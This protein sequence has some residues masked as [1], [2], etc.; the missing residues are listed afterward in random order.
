MSAEFRM[1]SNATATYDHINFLKSLTIRLLA[2]QQSLFPT[3]Y[4][5]F[6]NTL[7]ERIRIARHKASLAVNQ[8]LILLYWE[9]GQAILDQQQQEGWGAR[10]ID[11]L[12]KDIKSEFPTL[13]GFSAR[14]LAYMRGFAEAFSELEIVQ[15][16]FAQIPWSHTTLL[17][18]KVKDKEQRLWYA[19]AAIENGWSRAILQAQI[20][21]NL[22]DRQGHALTNFK[23]TLPKADSELAQQL[24]KSEYSLEFLQID[25]NYKER[26][27]EQ[28]LIRHMR[29]FLLELGMGFAFV[30]NQYRLEVAEEEFFIDLLFYH[31]HL[32]RYVVIEI[33]TTDFKPEYTGK[34]GFYVNVVDEYLRGEGDNSTIGIILCRSRKAPIVEFALKG[35]TQPLGVATY[36]LAENLPEDV[37][38]SLP[39]E[40][41]LAKALLRAA[42]EFEAKNL[43]QPT[44]AEEG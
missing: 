30:G 12:A 22:Y 26:D 13:R 6:L 16:V 41:Q 19:R 29:D 7:K 34:L 17:L 4:E 21:T 39:S 14:S 33:K 44:E 27:L 20:D 28:A 42:S 31:I 32:K 23:T 1:A 11:R 37:Q 2:D 3:D 10:V 43:A 35:T 5:A 9:I 15:T 18:D 36:R 40:D 8:E 25:P 38:Q 24:L